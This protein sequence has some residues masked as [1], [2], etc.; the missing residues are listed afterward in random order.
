VAQ[1][2]VIPGIVGCLNFSKKEMKKNPR[3]L[4]LVLCGVALI[5]LA[6]CV[7]S[8]RT[9]LICPPGTHPGPYGERCWA[10]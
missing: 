3:T 5:S 8:A 6:G 10:N 1:Y 2:L 7:E 4:L 9:G